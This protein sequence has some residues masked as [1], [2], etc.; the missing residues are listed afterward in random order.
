MTRHFYYCCVFLILFFAACQSENTEPDVNIDILDELKVELWEVLGA[1]QRMLEFRVSTLENLDCEN[2]SISFSLNRSENSAIISINNILPPHECAPGI[3]PASNQIEMGHF[4]EGEYS[5]QLNLKNNEIIN[6]GQL[7][8]RPRFY[9]LVME[10]AHGI[11][12]PWKLL[13]TVPEDLVWGYLTVEE[14]E[15]EN[16]ILEA[17][18]NTIAPWTEEVGLSQGEYGYFKIEGGTAVSIHNQ[19]EAITENIFLLKQTG[20][21]GELKTALDN[22]RN[23]FPDQVSIKAFLS[24]GSSL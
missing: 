9:E 19:R 22:L 12:L 18:D 8:I 21:Q 13:K 4:P 20:T 2:Y 23:E 14:E 6:V 11:F 5:I 17:F 3:A 1:S 10:S 7:N 15:D 16:D 24:N